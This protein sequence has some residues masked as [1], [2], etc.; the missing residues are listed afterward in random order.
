MDKKTPESP[1]TLNRTLSLPIV[2]FYGIGTILGAG[3]YV[4]VGKV[5]GLAGIYTPIAFLL[6]SFIALFTCISYSE[7]SANYP[8]SA[9]EAEYVLQAFRKPWLSGLVGWLVVITGIVS[10]AT[11][12]R[13]F[14]GYLEVFID[15]PPS[16]AM[17]LLVLFLGVI[18]IWGIRESATVV[19]I[20][21]LL[22]V[23]GLLL[24]ILLARDFPTKIAEA[25]S[26]APPLNI[27]ALLGITSGAFL[28]F[29]AFIGFEDMVN[30]AEEVKNPERTLPNAILIT[31]VIST[32]LYVLVA[33]AITLSVP[34]DVLAKSKAP[35]ADFIEMKGYS[36]KV[37]S[38]ISLISIING[39]LVQVIMGS[40]VI[41]GMSAHGSA[42][43]VFQKVNPITR[44]PVAA[45]L[46]VM[47]IIMILALWFDVV[48]LASVT[49]TVIICVFIMIHLSLI[50]IKYK[51]MHN[52][53]LISFSIIF[54]ILGVILSVIFLI[55]QFIPN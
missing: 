35:L 13:G 43:K 6:A 28:A 47:F 31:L 15:I 27:S 38:F 21:T 50:R 9:G 10:A 22:E 4:L 3:I 53:D 12:T 20:I 30:V 2:I 11:I 26:H 34:I 16:L 32:V 8:K 1:V 5:A 14:T 40:R 54:P 33:L 25:W 36:P 23:L 46:F 49:S 29:Y 18:A 42:P 19:I 55:L 39:A 48:F 7:L 37:I 17:I 52:K 24:I 44:T 51:E 41:Y 45:T